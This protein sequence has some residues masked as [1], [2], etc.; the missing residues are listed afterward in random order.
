MRTRAKGKQT[1]ASQTTSTAVSERQRESPK[2]VEN[3][4]DA[5]KKQANI[6][7]QESVS[8]DP[9]SSAGRGTSLGSTS[10]LALPFPLGSTAPDETDAWPKAPPLTST[11]GFG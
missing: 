10:S 5:W 2:S 7:D 4:E 1:S 9:S 8:N 3:Q 6:F 11:A